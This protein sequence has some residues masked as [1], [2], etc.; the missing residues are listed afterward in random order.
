[1][2]EW[3]NRTLSGN[4]TAKKLAFNS[5]RD[6][7]SFNVHGQVYN[8]PDIKTLEDRLNLAIENSITALAFSGA[9]ALSHIPKYGKKL[10]T[11]AMGILGWETGGDTFEDKVINSITLMGLHTLFNPV[12]NKKGFRGSTEDLLTEIYPNLSKKEAQ[13]ISKQLQFNILSAKKR[14]QRA[15]KKSLYYY[16]QRKLSLLGLLDL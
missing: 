1:M 9:G 2:V 7:L 12:P 8:R 13:R 5:A 10:G 15:C 11:T 14:Y 16:Y 4:K 3:I 6:L